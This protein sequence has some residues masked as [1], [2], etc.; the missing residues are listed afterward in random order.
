MSRLDSAIRR[1]QAQRT[2]L[3]FACAQVR[4]RPGAV[5]ELGL[6]NGRTYDHLRSRLADPEERWPLYVFERQVAAHPDCIPPEERL[7]LGDFAETLP[8]AARDLAGRVVLAHADMGSGDA[9]ANARLAA[10]VSQALAPALA[11]GALVLS[12]Q[13]LTLA[14]AE[15]LALPEGVAPGRYHLYR[16]AG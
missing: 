14:G 4:A 5:F 3:E 9:A 7:Y 8:R 12:D 16:K 2:C 10:F 11:P 15:P 1:L 13:P 6:G